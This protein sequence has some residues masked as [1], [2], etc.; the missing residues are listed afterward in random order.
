MKFLHSIRWRLQIWY[1]LLLV[2][3][4]LGFGMAMYRVESERQIRRVDAEL[5]RRVQVLDRSRHPVPNARPPRQQFTLLAENAPLF[6]RENGGGYYYYVWLHGRE[7]PLHSSS[8]PADVPLP[9]AGEPLTRMRQNFRETFLMPDRGDCL[10]VGHPMDRED[11]ELRQLAW[12]LVV[13][14]GGVL[15]VGLLGGAWLVNRALRPIGEISRAAQKVATGDLT[16]RISPGNSGSELGQLVEVLNSTFARLD[17]SFTQQAR[18]TADAAHE[19]RTPVSVILAHA[20]YGLEGPCE[21]AEHHEAFEATQRAAQ[22]MRRLIDSLLEL[23]RLDAGQEPG[24]REE[25]DLAAMASDCLELVRPMADQRGIEIQTDLANAP[26]RCDPDR[27]P[28]VIAN[29]LGNAI[30]HNCEGG[31]VRVST[32]RTNGVARFYVSNSGPGIP[33]EDLPHI[34]DRFYRA[35]KARS[36]GAGH[37]GL[38]LA[39]AKAIVQAHGGSIQADSEAGKGAT[40]TVTL[41]G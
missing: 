9:A 3:V 18:F 5:H 23:A 26:C 39:I 6:E 13:A 4:L 16:Q 28:Q 40:F 17:T 31:V 22:R 35:D 34:F 12:W 29:L 41:P 20:Q 1:G 19:L 25:C 11:G 36:S 33:P 14:G 15:V 2:A 10:L 7:A 27:L 30:E 38:G 24:H 32:V 37:S 21:N 8:A